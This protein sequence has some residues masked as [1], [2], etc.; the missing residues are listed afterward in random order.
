MCVC[1]ITNILYI[2]CIHKERHTNGVRENV[3]RKREKRR[4]GYVYSRARTHT[5]THTNITALHTYISLRTYHSLCLSISYVYIP[6]YI[7]KTPVARPIHTSRPKTRTPISTMHRV[8]KSS[9][10][11]CGMF[12]QASGLLS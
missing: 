11:V 9:Y 2:I 8:I 7:Y 5:H 3:N 6:M 4:R 10:D 1:G 12:Q